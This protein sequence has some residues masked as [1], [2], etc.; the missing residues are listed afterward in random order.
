MF[1]LQVLFEPDVNAPVMEK[2]SYVLRFNASQLVALSNIYFIGT[3]GIVGI[4]SISVV[5]IEECGF[6]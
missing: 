2:A 5:A 6:R 4:D 1:V 3:L